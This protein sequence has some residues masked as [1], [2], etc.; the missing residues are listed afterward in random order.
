MLRVLLIPSSPSLF[1]SYEVIYVDL[2]SSLSMGRQGGREAVVSSL[3]LE[4]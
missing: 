3:L 4:S 2:E 1:L